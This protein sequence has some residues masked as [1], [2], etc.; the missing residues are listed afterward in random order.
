M[1]RIDVSTTIN[2]PGE[3]VFALLSDYSNGSKWVSGGFKANKTSDGPIGV[4]TTWH[5][6]SKFLGRPMTSDF[7]Y[8]EFE[9]N[10]K[11]V[12]TSTKPFP[13]TSTVMFEPV[14]GGTRVHQVGEA[15]FGGFLKLAGPLVATMARRQL[16][17][18]L[19]NLRALM[20]AHSL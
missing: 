15:E 13:M 5:V 8:T 4:G 3:D 19:D 16:Q 14:A 18:D 11:I 1:A 7:E 12:F 6:V 2:R 20:D 17:S 9:P 10:R